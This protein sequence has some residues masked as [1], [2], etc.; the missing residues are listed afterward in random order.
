MHRLSLFCDQKTFRSSNTYEKYAFKVHITHFFVESTFQRYNAFL[1]SVIFTVRNGT[2]LLTLYMNWSQLNHFVQ[3]KLYSNW[4]E[5][6][7]V[8]TYIVWDV[9]LMNRVRIFHWHLELILVVPAHGSPWVW[10]SEIPPA[11]DDPY[12]NTSQGPINYRP[13][14]R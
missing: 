6:I 13:R 9:F 3:C 8:H 5:V 14:G 7:N 1:G 10:R 12:L 11:Y 2:E 4:R